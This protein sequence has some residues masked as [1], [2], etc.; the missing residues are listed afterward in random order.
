MQLG[1]SVRSGQTSFCCLSEPISAQLLV[2]HCCT[3]VLRV[4]LSASCSGAFCDYRKGAERIE[5][6]IH[7]F[8]LDN[9]ATVIGLLKNWPVKIRPFILALLLYANEVWH[10]IFQILKNTTGY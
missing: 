4:R 5:T 7:S 6:F 1:S 3:C 8:E 9:R 10:H 2:Q